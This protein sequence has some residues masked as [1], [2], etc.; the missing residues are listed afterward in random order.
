MTD[1]GERLQNVIARAGV[2][3][4]RGAAALVEAGRVTVDGVVVTEPGRR[5]DPDKAAVAVDGA[6]VARRER[7]RTIMLYKP[8]GV[9]STLAAPFGGK[10]VAD[11][12][13][14]KVAERLVPVGRLDRDSEGLLL[15]SNDGDLV[16]RL[17]HPRFGH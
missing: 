17:T 16:L 10:T 8:A 4:R 11:L 9:L 3:S 7:V 5:V 2:A 12:L 14:G 15:M 13:R 1:G 6:P